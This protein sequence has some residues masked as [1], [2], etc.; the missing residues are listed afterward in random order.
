MSANSYSLE[1]IS[2]RL[3]DWE[4]PEVYNQPHLEPEG[5]IRT[6]EHEVLADVTVVQKLG[7]NAE[8]FTLMGDGYV[9]DIADLREMRGDTV[10]LRHPI[11]SGNVLVESVGAT[12]TGEWDDG[13]SDLR[14]WV[15]SYTVNLTSVV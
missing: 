8:T 2:V 11:H 15:Y 5:D 13:P 7:E 9:V 10:S 1:R 3:G 14:K 4:P 12:H 6:Q